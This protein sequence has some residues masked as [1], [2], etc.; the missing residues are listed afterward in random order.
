ML[1]VWAW[2]LPALLPSPSPHLELPKG[3]A[4]EGEAA[5]LS[6]GASGCRMPWHGTG[7][8]GALW[9]PLQR[10]QSP[11]PCSRGGGGSRWCLRGSLM[12]NTS[13]T[14]PQH[15]SMSRHRLANAGW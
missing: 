13:L 11:V 12:P 15:R 7:T 10:Q 2:V 14:H 9:E 1:R 5:M 4:G 6:P 3:A 8:A